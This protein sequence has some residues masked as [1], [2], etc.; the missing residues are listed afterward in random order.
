MRVGSRG[1]P[2]GRDGYRNGA[3]R[4]GESSGDQ[5]GMK[6][7][8]ALEA[9]RLL[10]G[11]GRRNVGEVIAAKV[12]DRELAKHIVEDRG[13]VLDRVVAVRGPP[14]RSA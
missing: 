1:F 4:T 5:R 10:V 14:A 7:S 6:R 13:C 11:D 12:G 3:V 9:K 8:G 2:G